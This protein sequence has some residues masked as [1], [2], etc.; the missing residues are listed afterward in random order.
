[1]Q[2]APKQRISYWDNIKGLMIVLV[3]F[4]HVLLSL[5]KISAVSAHTLNFIYMFHMPVFVF[6]SGFFGKSTHARSWQALGK[7]LFLYFIFNSSMGLFYGFESLLI[8]KYSYWYLLCL[9][10]WRALTPCI[11][12]FKRIPFFLLVI[13]LF[14]GFFDDIDNTFSLARMICFY[15]YYMAGYLLSEAKA[16]EVY[17]KPYPVRAMR[18]VALLVG[19]AILA[20]GL[21][22]HFHYT[23]S[24][25][26]M[27]PYVNFSSDAF[28]RIGLYAVAF[29][30]IW[31]LRYLTPNRAVAPLALFGRNS[32]WIFLFHRPV[33]L[34]IGPLFKHRPDAVV[35]PV[36]LLVTLGVCAVFG[37][38]W[39]AGRMEKFTSDGIALFDPHKKNR[40][41]A[42]ALA[43]LCVLGGFLSIIYRDAYSEASWSDIKNKFS[44]E[45]EV[46]NIPAMT[47]AKDMTAEKQ[48]SFDR[49][50]RIT[51]AGDLILLEDQV[52]RGYRGG[53]YD[54]ADVFEYAKPY[55]EPADFAIGVF[56][57]PMAGAQAGY[58]SGNFDDGKALLLNFPDAFATDVKQAGFDLVTTANNHLLDKG[59][60]GALRTL[61]VLDRVGLAHTGS[62]RNKHEKEKNRVKL[63]EKDGLKMAI[64]SYTYGSN[65]GD[66]EQLID[67]ELSYLTSVI[68]G[69]EGKLF[70]EMKR[71]VEQDFEQAKAMQPDLI[72]VLPHIG[73][74]FSNEPDGEQKTWFEIFKNNGADII[75]GDHP[76]VVEPVTVEKRGDKTIVTAY[77]PGNFANIY[78]KQQG[79]TSMLVDVYVDRSTKKIIGAGVVPLYTQ[80]PADGNFRALPIFEMRY[81]K[82][83][84]EQLS[85]DDLE[86]AK[87]AHDII[88]K[89]LFGHAWDVSALTPR[90]YMDES[91][92]LR[93]KQRGLKLSKAMQESAFLRV[94]EPAETICFVGDSV[95]EGTKNEGHPWYEPLE[96]FLSARAV[97]NY[98]RGGATIWDLVS[99]AEQIPATQA[100][101]IA[102]GT[103]DIRYREAG[104]G[105]M[106]PQDFIEKVDRLKQKL[107][108]KSPDATFVFIAPWYST[109]G[110]P[111]SPLSIEEKDAQNEIYSQALERYC[112][113]KNFLYINP[114]PYIKQALQKR[115]QTDYLLDHIHPN[116]AQ[117]IMLYSE[118]V[119]LSAH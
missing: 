62:Y 85:T 53:N 94:L 61:D 114:N 74:Q 18:G 101:V 68:S 77:C 59:V 7:L 108:E 97:L 37:N 45:T 82:Q 35:I 60:D 25:L 16:R 4:G 106:T 98:A 28:A 27:F 109:D 104:R 88:T 34:L 86:A 84:R 48:A 92:F 83:L 80:S 41:N 69:T 96:P 10:V 105:A 5:P 13:A 23:E 50:F 43:T 72:I 103:N 15:P 117:G 51:F 33:T 55:I 67:G 102:I 79:D 49:A 73:T 78:R 17:E 12:G 14:A 22:A 111:F 99:H 56:E 100:Y 76:H 87:S 54:F 31:A 65:V 119:L 89:V 42:A 113:D 6:I 46:I 36:A 26:E 52:K 66:T 3:V 112:R 75:L 40:F 107:A 38:A 20:A 24:A 90:Y 19:A 58:S 9:I 91:G 110:D 2:T 39:V 95:T 1:M 93:V 70:E 64:L 118:A 63:V 115:P 29:T 8:P 44:F 32:L 81:N 57:G 30:A 21:E 116:A 47:A 11:A 71:R